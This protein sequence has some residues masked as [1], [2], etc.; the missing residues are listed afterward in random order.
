MKSTI[1]Y[2]L[3]VF[4]P[5]LGLMFLTREGYLNST[6][7]VTCLF[8]YAFIYRPV[9]DFVRLKSKGVLNAGDWGKEYIIG[10]LTS[11][12]FVQLYTNY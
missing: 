11:R 9:I 4:L 1:F 12:Y 2:Y 10:Y 5:F 7:F 6:E 8:T 3:Y